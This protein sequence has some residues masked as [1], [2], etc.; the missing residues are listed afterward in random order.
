[1]SLGMN[2]FRSSPLISGSAGITGGVV[3]GLS[4]GNDLSQW[5]W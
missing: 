4:R 1:M 5:L 2:G 3:R